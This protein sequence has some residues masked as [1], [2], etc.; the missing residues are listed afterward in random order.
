MEM[1]LYWG[2]GDTVKTGLLCF[3]AIVIVYIQI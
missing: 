1:L 2:A 3:G